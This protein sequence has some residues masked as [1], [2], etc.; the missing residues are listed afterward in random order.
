MFDVAPSELLVVAIIALLFIG[1]KDLPLALRTLGRWV[2]KARRMSNHFRAGVE[3]MIREA[4]M[5]EIEREW[6][7]R[8]ARI[9][10]EH[11]DAE[12]LETSA[13]SA[14]P[15][16]VKKALDADGMPCSAAETAAQNA[17]ERDGAALNVPA[18]GDA[19]NEPQ[20]DR[21]KSKGPVIQPDEKPS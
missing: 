16:P 10:A 4:E 19:G 12:A 2:G 14:D 3:A 15:A 17:G 9:M 13:A 8:N 20:A 18:A 11:P 21:A 1:P 5:E 6:R 7:E